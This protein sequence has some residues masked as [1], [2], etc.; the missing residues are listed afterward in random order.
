MKEM[1]AL[2]IKKPIKLKSFMSHSNPGLAL[3]CQESESAQAPGTSPWLSSPAQGAD[4]FSV[5]LGH[6]GW[7]GPW[8]GHLRLVCRQFGFADPGASCRVEGLRFAASISCS[9]Q[10]QVTCASSHQHCETPPPSAPKSPDTKSNKAFI[11]Y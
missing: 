3:L 8:C 10:Q 4:V 11:F 9:A 7:A 6:E 1:P 5:L 2:G